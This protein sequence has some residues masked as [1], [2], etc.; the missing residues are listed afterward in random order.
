MRITP[1]DLPEDQ[2]ELRRGFRAQGFDRWIVGGYVRDLLLGKRP[3]DLDLCTD[4]TPDEQ[5][6]LYDKLGLRHV[7][8]G[9]EHGTV[10]VVLPSGPCEITSMR[11]DVTTDGRRATVAYT[12]DRREDAARRDLT[13]NAM[14]LDDDGGL[15]DPFGGAEDLRA[16]RARFVGSPDARMREDYL[17][18]LRWLR[19]HGWIAE[20]RPLDGD[21]AAAAARN[22]QGLAGISRERVWSEV[23][24]IL[25]GPSAVAMTAAL[26]ELGLARHVGL[27]A[28]SLDALSEA[29]AHGTGDDPAV[30]LAAY[31][32]YDADAVARIA[33]DWRWSRHDA[34]RA[35]YVARAKGSGG[36]PFRLVAVEGVRP[37]WA[38]ALARADG[39]PGLA[40]EVLAW[41]KPAFPVDGRALAAA[42]V[43]PGPAMGE[44]LRRLK[45]AWADSGYA[46]GRDDLLASLDEAAP[47]P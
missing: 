1:P 43:A 21:T 17:R 7:P 20:G 22:A 9:F 12:R 45:D 39:H 4:A 25:R 40:E 46:L 24:R 33:V 13:F 37:E 35:G 30:S 36:D 10:T 44:T 29:L 19:F 28:G 14:S 18:I 41:P 26:S 3:K 16:R 23:S 34:E 8:T 42:G 47:A 15:Y 32:G 31:L 2:R 11:R 38:A 27:P 6:A 5:V